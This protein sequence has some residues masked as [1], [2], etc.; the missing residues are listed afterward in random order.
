M[1]N[2]VLSLLKN[3]NPKLYGYIVLILFIASAGLALNYKFNALEKSIS[4]LKKNNESLKTELITEKQLRENITERLEQQKKDFIEQQKAVEIYSKIIGETMNELSTIEQKHAK[5]KA[6]VNRLSIG[7]NF[8]KWANDNVE[9][10]NK[11][12][13]IVFTRL[14]DNYAKATAGQEQPHKNPM[15]CT[16][17]AS[18]DTTAQADTQSAVNR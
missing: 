7:E 12:M 15:Q 14:L 16:A 3:I 1:I 8:G 9:N 18:R 10:L 17:P 11:C 4:E 5:L 6:Q 2:V 13:H